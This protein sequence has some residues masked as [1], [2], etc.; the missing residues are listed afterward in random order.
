MLRPPPQPVSGPG[1]ADYAH[2]DV[3]SLRL[4]DGAEEY[5]LFTPAEPIPQTAPMVVFLHG[6]SGINPR[7]YSAWI[8]HL[9]RRGNIVVY[10]RYQENL[11]ADVGDMVDASAVAVADAWTTLNAAEG[12]RPD[13][14]GIVLAGHSLGAMI[15]LHLPDLLA[16]TDLP[17]AIVYFIMQPG[18]Q[19]F[20]A[21]TAPQNLASEA[22][23]IVMDG[24]ADTRV[25][26]QASR[27]VFE[28][29]AAALPD[30]Q[31]ELITVVTEGRTTPALVA[32]H[33]SPLAVDLDFPPDEL[34]EGVVG[35]GPCAATVGD[36][37][38]G[39]AA[40]APDALDYYGYW[41]LLDGL[42]DAQFFDR[43]KRYALG[44][45]PE[46]RFLGRLPDGTR[47]AQ[48]TVV[49]SPPEP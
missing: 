32:D 36:P 3:E 22:L 47:V 28:A 9:V 26:N 14:R 44:D 48:L 34:V 4:G 46:Q 12:V 35:S 21:P 37:A 17:P 23:V 27:P 25:G 16:D 39:Q 43:N 42:I 11:F 31:V 13:P 20:L 6:W 19:R 40:K 18:G 33:Y 41:K 5:W 1:G 7:C 10:P 38:A 24:D 49:Q 2:A 29:L 30:G 8:R 15:A 45:T